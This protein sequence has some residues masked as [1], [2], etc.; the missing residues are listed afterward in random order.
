MKGERGG[1]SRKWCR[2]RGLEEQRLYEMVNLRRQFKAQ[3]HS[4]FTVSSIEF[5]ILLQPFMTVLFVLQD[6]LRGHGLLESELSTTSEGDRGQRRERL[7][8][9][10]KLRQLK[11]DHEQQETTKRKVLKLDE[12][13]DDFSSGSDTERTSRGKKDKQASGPS[14]DIQVN[15]VSR[16]QSKKPFTWFSGGGLFCF[17]SPSRYRTLL[18]ACAFNDML[19]CTFEA[20]AS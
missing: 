16:V 4:L 14:V 7:T 12:G 18:F 5:F 17:S 11:R 1:G 9:R 13:Q 8:E 2:R 15:L 10:K 20:L 3:L 6:L 19:S